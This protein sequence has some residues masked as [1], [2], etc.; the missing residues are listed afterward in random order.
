[1]KKRMR[2]PIMGEANPQPVFLDNIDDR[3]ICR[4]PAAS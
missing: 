2:Q 1:V 3:A 4:A